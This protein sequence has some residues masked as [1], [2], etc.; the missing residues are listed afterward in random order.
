MLK[1]PKSDSE[2]DMEKYE[3][4]NIIL[5]ETVN[6]L[7]EPRGNLRDQGNSGGNEAT[8]NDKVG[9]DCTKFG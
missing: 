8:E 4:K 7:E 9:A 3:V 6:R 1:C 2:Y 5:E